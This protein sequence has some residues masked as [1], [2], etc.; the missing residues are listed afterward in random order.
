[1][2]RHYKKRG[3]GF[4][5]STRAT[6]YLKDGYSRLLNY[7]HEDGGFTYWG[8]GEADQALT[9]Y[10]LQF[11]NDAGE[12]IE[13]DQDVVK[14]AREWL[15]KRQQ[16]NGSWRP[17]YWREG[18]SSGPRIVLTAYLARVLARTDARVSEPLKRAL[19]FLEKESQGI[20][21]PYL[22]ASYALAATDAKDTARAKPAVEKLRTLALEEGT[23]LYWAIETNTPF[24]G[25][26][27]A[28]RIE[29]T[30]L[31][32]Q[33]LAKDCDSQ[34]AACEANKKL[35]NR[36]L[37]FL[38]KEKDRYG[39]WCSTQATVNVLDAMLV[40]FSH[41]G[42]SDPLS[43][44][45]ADIV[46]NGNRMQTVQLDH[47]LNNPVTVNITEFLKAGKNSVEFKRLDG[48][49][50]A[51]VQAVANYYVPWSETKPANNHSTNDLR[52]Q[53]QFDKTAAK[54]NEDVTCRVEAAR[55]GFRGYGMLLAEIG[56]PPGAEVDRS[57]LEKASK[58]WTIN[59][60]DVLP[61]RVVFYLWPKA[62]GV[63]FDFKFR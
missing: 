12:L 15:V 47:R 59:R 43:Q 14:Q 18:D 50:F 3:E 16:P 46:V 11:L 38:L 40:L 5:L 61:D 10:A 49:P 56:I 24:Y 54:I 33:A 41:G 1:M 58:D 27:R 53:V 36:G 30:A 29:T 4:A 31:V 62:G 6:R 8:Y 2:L 48:L 7:R 57:S 55:V 17:S 28:G 20:A 34:T 63:S 42:P 25:W 9:A 26:G 44:S 19:D 52:L 39:V 22:L 60:Y 13:V 51:S 23:T 45:T 35:I 21:E 32:I 37:L